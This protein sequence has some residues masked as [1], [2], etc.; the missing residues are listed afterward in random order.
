MK[1]LIFLALMTAPAFA[2][3]QYCSDEAETYYVES[4]PFGFAVVRAAYAD[5]CKQDHMSANPAYVCNGDPDYT[6]GFQPS[7]DELEVTFPKGG[8]LKF[9]ACTVKNASQ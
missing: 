7:G 4:I 3:Q 8:T 5:F 2:G 9:T 6:M 1:T